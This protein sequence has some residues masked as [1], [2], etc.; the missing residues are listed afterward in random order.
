MICRTTLDAKAAAYGAFMASVFNNT[1]S[2]IDGLVQA[3]M[4]GNNLAFSG[5]T[6]LLFDVIAG[7]GW[8]NPSVVQHPAVS[9]TALTNVLQKDLLQRGIN[10]IWGQSKIYVTFANLNDDAR[11]TKCK[12]DVNG[13]QASKT[14]LDGGVYYLYR[15]NEAGSEDGNLDYPWGA[16]QMAGPPWN[17]NPRVSLASTLATEIVQPANTC[18]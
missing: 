4:S 9:E 3:L 12:A 17:L 10:F 14:C 2:G 18:L 16:D 5:G 7:G 8:A 13:W 1:A 11:G 6:P 15:F